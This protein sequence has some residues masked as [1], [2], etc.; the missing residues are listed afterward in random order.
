MRYGTEDKGWHRS[1]VDRILA[2]STPVRPAILGVSVDIGWPYL[3]VNQAP[4]NRC[5]FD[6][7]H[8]HQ[9][10]LLAQCRAVRS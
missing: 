9:F 5:Q 10:G 6:S 7:G 4:K 3:T 2:G 8:S 1:I